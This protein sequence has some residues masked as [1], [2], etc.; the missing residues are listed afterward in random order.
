[1][2]PRKAQAQARRFPLRPGV[3]H[4]QTLLEA[5]AGG[6]IVWTAGVPGARTAMPGKQESRQKALF[7]K[8]DR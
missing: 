8:N 6:V 5:Q 7:L 3:R 1:M 4:K 2:H